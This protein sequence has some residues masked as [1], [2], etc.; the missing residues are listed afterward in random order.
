VTR[1][2]RHRCSPEFSGRPGRVHGAAVAAC[3]WTPESSED[4]Q[5]K[6]EMSGTVRRGSLV[7]LALGF[8]L[9]FPYI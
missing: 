6:G 1:R 2:R 5:I 4:A 7:C 9:L 3:A 8:A